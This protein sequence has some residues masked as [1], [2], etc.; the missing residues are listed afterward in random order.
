MLVSLPAVT[1]PGQNVRD[2]AD[3][4]RRD[5]LFGREIQHAPRRDR[6]G[7]RAQRGVMPAVFA[8]ARPPDFAKPHLDFVGDDRRENQIFAAQSFAFAE[9]QRRGDEIA[10]VTRI[11]LPIN[12]VVIH[13]ADHVAIQ[14]CRIDRVGFESGNKCGGFSIAAAHAR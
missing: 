2:G 13:R 9:R 4:D 11:G 14:K 6:R 10:R 5:H 8:N 7:E 1:A 3:A 12:V